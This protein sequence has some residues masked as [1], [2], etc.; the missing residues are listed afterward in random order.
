MSLQLNILK[1]VTLVFAT[2][3]FLI[4]PLISV[5]GFYGDDQVVIDQI[6][7][8]QELQAQKLELIQNNEIVEGQSIINLL[9][10][11]AQAKKASRKSRAS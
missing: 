9:S 2:L 5:F 4:S 3:L 7:L 1:K 8:E 6:L 10:A 11:V